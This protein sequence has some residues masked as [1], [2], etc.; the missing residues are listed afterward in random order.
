MASVAIATRLT[1]VSP[2]ETST[3]AQED[4]TT[5]IPDQD[6][7][8]AVAIGN[9]VLESQVDIVS[10]LEYLAQFL[11]ENGAIRPPADNIAVVMNV[12]TGASNQVRLL[13]TGPMTED[14]IAIIYGVNFLAASED[15]L[16]NIITVFANYLI[17]FLHE[18]VLK[19]KTAAA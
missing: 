12:V 7:A 8:M 11:R 19:N 2:K 5:T 3:V 14:D 17:D 15:G 16:S 9:N 10:K 18:A 4:W 1:G 6:N 13:P